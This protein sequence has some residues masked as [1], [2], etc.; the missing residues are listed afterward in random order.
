M[1]EKCAQVSGQFKIDCIGSQGE[2]HASRLQDSSGGFRAGWQK[3]GDLSN[4]VVVY[5][6]GGE[7]ISQFSCL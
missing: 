4:L 1:V 5:E 6:L 3:C 2:A 7:H